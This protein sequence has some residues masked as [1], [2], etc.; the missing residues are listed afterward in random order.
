MYIK[1]K[2]VHENIVNMKFKHTP[3]KRSAIAPIACNTPAF[4][5]GGRSGLL[6]AHK[7]ILS[8]LGSISLRPVA[9]ECSKP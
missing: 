5:G 4:C 8:I 2:L 7:I 9:A 3:S 1:W 6:S